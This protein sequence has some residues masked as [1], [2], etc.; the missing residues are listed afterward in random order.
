MESII[1]RDKPGMILLKKIDVGTLGSFEWSFNI[2]RIGCMR[3]FSHLAIFP[4][5]HRNMNKFMGM[6]DPGDYITYKT[7]KDTMFAMT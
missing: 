3:S 2:I 4:V 7:I 6:A 1:K 5:L